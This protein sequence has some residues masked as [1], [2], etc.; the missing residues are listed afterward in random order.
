LTQDES[1]NGNCNWETWCV[2]LWLSNDEGIYHETIEILSGD[3]EYNHQRYSALEDY[4]SELL[5]QKII[6]DKISLHRVDFEEVAEGFSE[7]SDQVIK[8]CEESNK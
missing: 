4:V 3:F 8:D 2:G 5:D 1:Y 6:T 7:E